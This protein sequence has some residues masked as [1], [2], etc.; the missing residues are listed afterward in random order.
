MSFNLEELHYPLPWYHHVLIL[1][2]LVMAISIIIHFISIIR[3]T[4]LLG[5]R[6][7][8]LLIRPISLMLAACIVAICLSYLALSRTYEDSHR[9][10]AMIADNSMGTYWLRRKLLDCAIAIWFSLSSS[11]ILL[12]LLRIESA[13]NTKAIDSHDKGT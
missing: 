5:F 10:V 9:Q 1:I 11:T 8:M 3:K 7:S 13:L 4:Y 2:F 12:S 6:H